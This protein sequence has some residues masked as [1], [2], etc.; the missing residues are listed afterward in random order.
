LARPSIKQLSKEDKSYLENFLG[1]GTDAKNLINHFKALGQVQS[2]MSL[3]PGPGSPVSET[4]KDRE[5]NDLKRKIQV[6]VD[7]TC[8]VI[9]KA[10]GKGVVLQPGW[11]DR[12]GFLG[13]YPMRGVGLQQEE[14]ALA[15]WWCPWQLGHQAQHVCN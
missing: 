4:D 14:S 12:L 10:H 2:Q 11:L 1:D 6:M 5:I 9:E 7:T 3:L 15:L 13:P 8:C